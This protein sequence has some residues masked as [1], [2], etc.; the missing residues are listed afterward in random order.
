MRRDP[1]VCVCVDEERPPYAYVMLEGRA[2]LGEDPEE[3]L[4]LATQIGGRYM[5]LDRAEEY[6]RRNAVP[7]E[8]LVRVSPTR[9]LAEDRIAD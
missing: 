5:G 1:R 2:S 3:M 6:G 7:G 4:R 8:I 9:V